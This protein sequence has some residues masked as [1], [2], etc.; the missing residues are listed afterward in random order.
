MSLP[1][2]N[3]ISAVNSV[4]TSMEKVDNATNQA[5]DTGQIFAVKNSL[6]LANAQLVEMQQNTHKNAAAQELHNSKIN[7]GS[8]G[9]G[10]MIGKFASMAGA[11][12]GI[13]KITNLSDQMSQTTARLNLM[14]DGLQ[15]TEELNQKIFASAQASK[16]SYTQTVG[17]VSKLGQRAG[18]AFSSNGETIAFAENLNKSFVIAGTSQQEVSSATLQLTQALGSGV[19]RGEELNAVFEA[20]PNIIQTIADYM[21]VPIGKVRE[22]AAEGGVSAEIVKNAMLV[23]T[24]S[25]NAD[26]EKMPMTWAQVWTGICNE[27]TFAIQPILE[28]INMLAQNWEILEPIVMGAAVAVGLYAAAMLISNTVTGAGVALK[29]I[30]TA[31]TSHWTFATFTA[32]AAQSGFNAAMLA[33]PITWIVIA[34]IALVA[35]FYAVVAAMNKAGKISESAS[36]M[37]MGAFF[38]AGA[39]IYNIVIGLFNSIL[40]VVNYIVNHFIELANF[41][42]NIFNNPISSIIYSFQGMAD[43][44][45]GI[46]ET[47]ASAID[48]V[49]GSKLADSVAGWRSGLKEMADNAVEK[50]AP[51]EN[52]QKVFENIDLSVDDFGW[53]RKEYGAAYEKGYGVGKDLEA[54]VSGMFG[55]GLENLIPNADGIAAG[56]DK[57]AANTGAMADS[58]ETS[59]EELKYMRDIAE[60]DTINRFTTAEIKVDMTNNNNVSSGMDLDGIVDH[61]ATGVNYAMGVAAEGVHD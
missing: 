41:F 53:E 9:I 60:R 17:M 57:T 59:E 34:V 54:K 35:V 55:G 12:M 18:D 40:G 43:G 37:I 27:V 38:A 32:T 44:V 15:T 45:L 26:F 7:A 31:F 5:F 50:Y 29:A 16:A 24:D 25:I 6:G 56:V 61:L 4:V 51:N 33:C 39:Y 20:A 30:H 58:L 19:L 14:N 1:L 52:Y 11:F 2:Q 49:F 22:I 47:I 10:G 8:G 13:S 28:L 46:I 23:A 21:N 48:F 36:G 3:I 42:G